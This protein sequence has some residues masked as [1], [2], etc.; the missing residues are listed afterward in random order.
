LK[1]LIVGDLH[2]KK[3]NIQERSKLLSWIEGLTKDVDLLVYLGDV[4]HD[5]QVMY[6]NVHNLFSEH[7]HR[8]SIETIILEGNHDMWKPKDTS[9]SSLRSL[10]VPTNVTIVTGPTNIHN[11]TFIPFL[12]DMNAFPNVGLCDVVFTHNEF[13]GAQTM[14]YKFDEGVEPEDINCNLII[15]GHIHMN[16][17][18]GKLFYPGTPVADGIDDANQDKGVHIYDTETHLFDFIE[19]PFPKIFIHKVTPEEAGNYVEPKD[20]HK[21][22][23]EIIGERRAVLKASK[24]LTGIAVRTKIVNERIESRGLKPNDILKEYV[25]NKYP[26]KCQEVLE[27]LGKYLGG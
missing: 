13:K 14:F 18:L 20:G 22:I 7:L 8:V 10:H 25:V 11:M 27:L 23:V 1:V 24:Q 12:P 9:H 6:S 3:S 5:H 4:F 17:T 26:Q 19:S 15:S 21:H 16:Q 2:L